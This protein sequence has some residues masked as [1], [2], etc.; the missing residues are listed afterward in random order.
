VKERKGVNETPRRGGSV[1]CSPPWLNSLFIV[2]GVDLGLMLKIFL[3]D[4]FWIYFAFNH[5]FLRLSDIL[6]IFSIF[7]SFNLFF[8]YLQAINKKNIK[9]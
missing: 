3:N 8:S 4:I 7:F 2:V 1:V 5:I 6:D 9:S